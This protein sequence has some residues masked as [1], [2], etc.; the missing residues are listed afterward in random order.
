MRKP[1]VAASKQFFLW[2]ILMKQILVGKH[3][4]SHY[5]KPCTP[6]FK[7]ILFLILRYFPLHKNA[8]EA[9]GRFLSVQKTIEQPEQPI[10]HDNIFTF[11]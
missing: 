2:E 1:L 5:C 8:I 9:S 4:E 6:I 7:G 10:L 3:C 11:W